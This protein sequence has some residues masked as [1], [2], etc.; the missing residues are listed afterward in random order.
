MGLCLEA[1]VR[2]VGGGANAKHGIVIVRPS[3]EE[4][5]EVFYGLGAFASP[6]HLR[7]A[8]RHRFFPL[9]MNNASSGCSLTE[10]VQKSYLLLTTGL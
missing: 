2:S 10:P 9:I 5:V 1:L 3:T 4:D 6:A 8:Q 7:P